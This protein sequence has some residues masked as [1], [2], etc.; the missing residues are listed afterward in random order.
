[1]DRA[2]PPRAELRRSVWVVGYVISAALVYIVLNSFV[3]PMAIFESAPALG[4][5]ILFGPVATSFA[6]AL[7][8]KVS[9]ACFAGMAFLAA[10]CIAIDPS[11]RSALGLQT[12]F[13]LLYALAPAALPQ[14][15]IWIVSIV[16]AHRP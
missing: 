7:R 1:M 10:L 12:A 6:G 2:L 13:V 16:R 4:L 5:L 9:M 15:G 8:P 11:S 14:V 3:Y